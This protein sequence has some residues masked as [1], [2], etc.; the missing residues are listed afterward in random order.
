MFDFNTSMVL[1]LYYRDAFVRHFKVGCYCFHFAVCF[2]D[3]RR[4][5]TIDELLDAEDADLAIH[6]DKLKEPLY[7]SLHLATPSICLC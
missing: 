4:L 1:C 6:P 5:Q 2:A 3:R 7:V